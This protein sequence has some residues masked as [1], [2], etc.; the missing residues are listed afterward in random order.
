MSI[1]RKRFFAQQA[2]ND[3]VQNLALDRRRTAGRVSPPPAIALHGLDCSYETLGYVLEV[4][5]SVIE[6]EDDSPGADPA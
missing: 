3:F 4:L 6:A 5:V 1:V 2:A